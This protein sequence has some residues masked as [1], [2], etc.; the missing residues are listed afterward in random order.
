MFASVLFQRGTSG[1]VGLPRPLDARA[2]RFERRTLGVFPE[3]HGL[4]V[5]ASRPEDLVF[6]LLACFAFQNVIILAI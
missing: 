4:D 1:F 3:V 6:Q 5:F 2:R